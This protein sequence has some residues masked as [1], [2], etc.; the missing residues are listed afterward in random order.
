MKGAKDFIEYRK[1]GGIVATA[2]EVSLVL[3]VKLLL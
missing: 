3:I 1:T 2:Y